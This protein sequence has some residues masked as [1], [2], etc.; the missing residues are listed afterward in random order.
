MITRIDAKSIL[1]VAAIAIG[2]T[3]CNKSGC[4][5]KCPTDARAKWEEART[6]DPT[7]F[8]GRHAAELLKRNPR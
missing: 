2:A 7:G 6:K 3:G 1:V 5:T 8:D 4:P